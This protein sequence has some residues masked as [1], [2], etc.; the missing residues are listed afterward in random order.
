MWAVSIKSQ[1]V[2]S[3]L[4]VLSLG[5]FSSNS[6][7]DTDPSF[8]EVEKPGQT[9]FEMS[10]LEVFDGE[11]NLAGRT[12]YFKSGEQTEEIY[13]EDGTLYLVFERYSN[14]NSKAGKKFDQSGKVLLQEKFYAESGDV[15]FESKRKRDG[16]YHQKWFSSDGNLVREVE[17]FS[18]NGYSEIH[19]R[20]DGTKWHGIS[21]PPDRTGRGINLYFSKDGKVLRRSFRGPEMIVVVSDDQGNELYRQHW[22]Q[23]A[24]RY[25]LQRVKESHANGY[26][27]VEISDGQIRTVG[28]H[29]QDGTLVKRESFE[30]LSQPVDWLRLHE[31]SPSDDPS[32][33]KVRLPSK[34]TPLGN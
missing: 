26:R 18:R 9:E 14:G 19:Y 30:N 21:H 6:F 15:F 3:I 22:L 17:Y 34:F 7:A 8:R 31:L 20:K 28:Y 11:G 16:H 24:T 33:P 13:R 25:H 4:V 10:R 29:H 1:F 23:G 27:I 5:F 32:V 12:I 2:P